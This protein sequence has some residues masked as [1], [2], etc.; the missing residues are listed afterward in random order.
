M[1][2]A[3]D[4]WSATG[5]EGKSAMQTRGAQSPNGRRSS[6]RVWEGVAGGILLTVHIGDLFGVALALTVLSLTAVPVL[7]PIGTAVVRGE[8]LPPAAAAVAG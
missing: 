5:A 2:V 8:D 4:R 6:N 3:D 7:Y 1:A